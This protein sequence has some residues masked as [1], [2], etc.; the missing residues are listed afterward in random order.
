MTG[1]KFLVFHVEGGIGKN[2]MAT[3]VVKAIKKQH[4]DREIIVVSPHSAIWLNNPDV[5]RVYVMGQTPYFYEDFIKGKDT[6]VIKSDPYLH[7]DYINKKVHCIEAWC[8]QN[9]IKYDNEQPLIHLTEQ[10]KSE[11][12]SSLAQYDKPLLLI[13]T[14]GGNDQGGYS[15]VRDMPLGLAADLCKELEKKWKILHIRTENQPAIPNVEFITSPNIRHIAAAIQYSQG[16]IL[17]D[18]LAQHAAKAFDR[19]STVLWPVDKVKQL[20][21]AFHDNLISSFK[22]IKTHMADYYLT[23]D[24]I[25][26]E[27]HMCPFPAGENIFNAEDVLASFKKTSNPNNFKPLPKV[28]QQNAMGE[29][30]PS[31]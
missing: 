19:R 7:Q 4:P 31:C 30:C 25:V 10:E 23:E 16:R 3:A 13:Q 5:Y 29:Q 15:W 14:N 9:D 17:I 27:S 1:K 12:Y 2:I 18:S 26:G 21:Y 28:E 11:V 8:L 22:P 24:D 6:I 20:G